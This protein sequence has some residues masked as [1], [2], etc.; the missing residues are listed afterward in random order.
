MEKGEEMR[1]TS[2]RCR[3]CDQRRLGGAEIYE[4]SG[5]G[6]ISVFDVTEAKRIASDSRAAEVVADQELRRMVEE[7]DVE[8]AHLAHVDPEMPGIIGQRF[9]GRFLIDGAHRAALALAEE[10]AFS[11]RVLSREETQS[12]LLAQD[13]WES[14]AGLAARELRQLL[15]NNPESEA[16]IE[17]D[18]STEDIEQVRRL[19]TPEENALIKIQRR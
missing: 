5:E 19:L 12:C 15:K 13:I 3:I 14:D 16:E 8:E 4:L 17:V 9:S 10:R 11:A 7:N 2:E 18:W 1:G 6:G